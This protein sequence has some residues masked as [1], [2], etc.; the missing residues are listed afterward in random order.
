[1]DQKALFISG[2][3]LLLLALER[4]FVLT[5]TTNPAGRAWVRKRR[6]LH[7]N[8]ISIV[9]IPMG[10]VTMFLWMAGWR[11]IA[12]VW[13][14]FW[15]ITDL[16]DGAIARN[17]DLGTPAGKWLDPLS[18]KCMYF[19]TL[20]YF[21]YH[22]VLNPHWVISLLIIDAAGQASRLF[23]RKKA[24]NLFGKAKTALITIL[25][26]LTALD[27]I[28]SISFVTARFL[29]LSTF[30]CALLAF[31]S[32]YCKVVPDTWYANTL[33][34]AN[35][36]CGVAAIWNVL[37]AHPLRAFVLVFLGQFFDLFDGRLARKFG[38]TPRGAV[39]DDIADATNF[40]LAV[41]L[42]VYYQLGR[43]GPAAIVA[44][45]FLLCT[46]YRL[47]RYLRR[48]PT[49]DGG[50]FLGLPSPAGAMLAGSAVLLFPRGHVGHVL[51]VMAS[52]LMVSH[53]RYRHFG[54]RIWPALPTWLKL[55]GF[56]GVLIFIN[57]SIAHR[58]SDAFATLAFALGVLY[59]MYGVA[60]APRSQ[61]P[62]QTAP[63]VSTPD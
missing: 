24:A 11:E 1:M 50:T 19:P 61:K 36:T 8:A 54:R 59:V 37:T 33:T 21:A 28:G 49:A 20:A 42:L 18:D 51:V 41:G 17:C 29:E 34:L 10:L 5:V 22:G 3:V 40:G 13:F 4:L 9:R 55:L 2:V 56:I 38:S 43:D 48:P 23:V 44:V 25:L 31:L 16:T 30:S 35:F 62:A 60:H 14:A 53:I 57:N 32:F 15:M 58:Q 47:L 27:Q 63:D 26:A 6:L 45:V 12:I 7:P 52:G 39:Y 46:V